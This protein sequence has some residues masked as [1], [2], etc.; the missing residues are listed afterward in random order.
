MQIFLM[1]HDVYIH[2]YN[3]SGF[4][5]DSTKQYKISVQEF[6]QQVKAVAEYCRDHDDIKVDFTFD[7]GG[8]SFATVVA[9]VLEKYGLRG[10]FF[11]S[12]KYIETETFISFDQ[13]VELKRRGHIIGSH[14]NSHP[15]LAK[16]AKG[17]E[18]RNGENRFQFKA[19]P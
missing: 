8:K 4:L 9:P 7:D 16:L 5:K 3:E 15:N 12:A 2:D 18:L 19:L 17:R 14:R 10:I 1:Y 13:I 11:I 6:E